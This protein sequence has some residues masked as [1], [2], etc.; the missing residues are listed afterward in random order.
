LKTLEDR[1]ARN[2]ATVEALSPLKVLVRGY[3]LTQFADGRVVRNAFDAAVGDQLRITLAS[4][5]LGATVTSTEEA[6]DDV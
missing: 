5:K 1:L 2:T 6:S 3:S 4:G